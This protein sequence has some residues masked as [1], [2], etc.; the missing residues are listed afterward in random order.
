MLYIWRDMEDIMYYKLLKPNETI[1]AKHIDNNW[2]DWM[3]IWLKIYN[4]IWLNLKNYQKVILLHE[5]ARLHVAI[6]V[7]QTVMEFVWE[8]LP[9]YSPDLAPSDYHLYLQSMQYVLEDTHFVITAKSKIGLL[10]WFKK[11]TILSSRNLTSAWE[12]IIASE[13]KYFD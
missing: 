10:D 11:Q 5:K 8:I 9:A 6:A 3:I 2:N 12:K 1:T 13:G 4:L 7:K